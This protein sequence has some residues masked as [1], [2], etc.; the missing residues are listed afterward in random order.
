[1]ETVE[2]LRALKKVVDEVLGELDPKHFDEPIRW[3]RLHC[4]SVMH[5][6]TDEDVY[7]LSVELEPAAP[8]CA[9]LI[10][11]VIEALE[12]RGWKGLEVRT[13]W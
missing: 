13:Q 2:S 11:H 12:E 7:Y 4:A 6:H 1:M 3:T 5:V 9:H 8:D 10:A